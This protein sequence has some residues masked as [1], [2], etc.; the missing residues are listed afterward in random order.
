MRR[1]E[2]VFLYFASA[3]AGAGI[4][5]VISDNLII[6]IVVGLLVGAVALNLY[7]HHVIYANGKRC[8]EREFGALE[9]EPVEE[10]DETN[11]TF[12]DLYA[13]PV[14]ITGPN[15][16]VTQIYQPAPGAF[17]V[18]A[19]EVVTNP[20]TYFSKKQATDR[21][22]DPDVVVSELQR[23]NILGHTSDKNNVY[24]P[25]PAGKQVLVSWLRNG[26]ERNY[27]IATTYVTN[28][29]PNL[30]VVG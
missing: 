29:Q 5:G 15:G 24:H 10:S 4:A 1:F 14:Q 19:S 25:T 3:A 28:T 17:A 30:P 13:H 21:G 6:A 23:A 16:Y 27:P 26:N 7:T 11:P 18:W 2:D 22:F 12:S 9:D 20:K 8:V